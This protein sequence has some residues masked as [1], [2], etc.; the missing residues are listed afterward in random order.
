LNKIWVNNKR[1]EYTLL[2]GQFSRAAGLPIDSSKEKKSKVFSSLT[3]KRGMRL[4]RKAADGTQGESNMLEY[5]RFKVIH[6]LF[7]KGKVEEARQELAAM[8]RRYVIL[9]DENTTFKMQIQEFEDIL[10]LARN[11]TFDGEFYWLE[12]GSIKQGPF[13]PNCYDRDGLLMRLS[14]E[15][16]D[17]FCTACRETY[18]QVDRMAAAV[19]Q[20]PLRADP[21]AAEYARAPDTRH[22]SK[23]IPF[24]R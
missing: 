15:R 22:R 20:D 11:L 24:A 5:Y 8:Q 9:C 10:Y 12:T 14:G 21:P 4:P 18:K 1:R 19:P 7:L 16:H 23:V 6:D 2:P 17:R 3:E 13:C